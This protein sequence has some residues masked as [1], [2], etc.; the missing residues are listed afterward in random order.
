MTSH[1][2]YPVYVQA[3]RASSHFDSRP[4][5]AV[6]SGIGARLRRLLSVARLIEELGRDDATNGR[7]MRTREEFDRAFHQARPLLDGLG[8][9]AEASR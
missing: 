7:P 4:L 5:E 1:D 9:L 3:Y 8:R 2:L 6:P